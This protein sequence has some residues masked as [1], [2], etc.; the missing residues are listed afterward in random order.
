M[1]LKIF[2]GCLNSR[3]RFP[4]VRV[5]KARLKEFFVAAV[6]ANGKRLVFT[7]ALPHSLRKRSSGAHKPAAE[8]APV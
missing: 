4:R 7:A 6:D 8:A 1:I 5:C 3:R 2:L